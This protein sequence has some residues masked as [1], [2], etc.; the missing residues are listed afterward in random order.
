MALV[1]MAT[2]SDAHYLDCVRAGIGN[3]LR[4]LLSGVLRGA[5]PNDMVELLK[6]LDQPS[7]EG[8]KSDEDG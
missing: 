1:I 7:Q 5:I 6:H 3:A 2:R 4:T 8:H